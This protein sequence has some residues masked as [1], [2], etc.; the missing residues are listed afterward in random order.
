VKEFIESG[1]MFKF[2]DE[3]NVI[4]YDSHRFY[5]SLSGQSMSGVDFAGILKGKESYMIEVKNF[6]QYPSSQPDKAIDDFVLEIVEKA[7]DSIQLITVIQKYLNR[8]FLYKAFYNLVKKY[9]IINQ[10]WFFWSELY[11]V[12]IDEQQAKFILLIDSH[13]DKSKIQRA[14]SDALAMEYKD[15]TVLSL[16]DN[17]AIKQLMIGS[18]K[19][20]RAN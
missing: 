19:V 13:Y 10:E 11:R 1:Y 18:E 5:I 3:W 8:K 14:L 16:R 4:K 17:D 7:K 15:V 9:P 12:T 2:G 6:K 20:F